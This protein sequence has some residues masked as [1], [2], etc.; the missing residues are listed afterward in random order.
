VLAVD[1][2]PSNADEWSTYEVPEDVV[3]SFKHELMATNVGIS[4]QTIVKP[5]SL[6]VL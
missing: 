4:P 3:Q 6:A 1:A 2:I 5:A